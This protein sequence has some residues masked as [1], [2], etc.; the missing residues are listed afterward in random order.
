MKNN[1]TIQGGLLDLLNVLD[2]RAV[3]DVYI[4]NNGVQVGSFRGLRVY[5]ILTDKEIY[6]TYRS[7][8][9]VGLNL[10]L[11]TCILIEEEA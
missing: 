2:A 8:K 9:V 4:Q 1:A 7:Y 11:V 3:V 5:E 6:R 10:S